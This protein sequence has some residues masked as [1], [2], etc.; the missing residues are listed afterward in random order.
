VL[1]RVVSRLIR[2]FV[3]LVGLISWLNKKIAEERIDLVNTV[4]TV[5]TKQY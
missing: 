1:S 5:L 2:I 3:S 4:L